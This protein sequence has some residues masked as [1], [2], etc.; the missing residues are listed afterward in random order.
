MQDLNLKKLIKEDSTLRGKI[1]KTLWP[2]ASKKVQGISM[3]RLI[4]GHRK[5]INIIWI[6]KLCDMLGKDPNY[7]FGYPWRKKVIIKKK[8]NG[9]N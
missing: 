9:R 8:E 7:F 3:S 4:N 5:S 2:N 1:A 6:I